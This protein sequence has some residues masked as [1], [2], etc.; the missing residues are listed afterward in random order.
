MPLC[1]PSIVDLPVRRPVVCVSPLATSMLVALVAAL[2]LV[3]R[4]QGAAPAVPAPAAGGAGAV[5]VAPPPPPPPFYTL[6]A[7]L[8]YVNTSGNTNTQTLNVADQLAFNTSPFNKLSQTF[9]LV[10]GTNSNK[11][12]TSQWTAGLRDEYTFGQHVG[13]YGLFNFD[14]NTFAGIKERFEEG[15]G[16]AFI[17]IVTAHDKLEIDIGGSF[18]N[19]TALVTDTTGAVSDSTDRY[20][21]LRTALIYR[22][23]FIKET[24]IQ[25]A[26]EGIPDLKTSSNYR[27]T[28][29]TDLVAPLSK[30]I[31][32]KIGYG[33]KYANLPPVGYQTMDRLFTSDLQFNF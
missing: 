8:G 6:H 20:V 28:S 23:T 9:A 21:A 5:A 29:Q 15:A 17:P 18:V 30:H 2:P 25:E 14:R 11:V 1:R 12:Q 13:V 3:V 4:A 31:A 22:H 26:I 19:V 16:V 24:Y 7:D 32:I 27:V 10:Y 33:I